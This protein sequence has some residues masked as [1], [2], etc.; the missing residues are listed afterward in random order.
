VVVMN[1]LPPFFYFS[2]SANIKTF[3]K[4]KIFRF[5]TII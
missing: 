2:D 1:H 4:A 5:L 3:S